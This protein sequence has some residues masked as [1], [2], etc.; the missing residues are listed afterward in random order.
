MRQEGSKRIGEEAFFKVTGGSQAEISQSAG[1][2]VIGRLI[3]VQVRDACR[4][5]PTKLDRGT[6]SILHS[7]DDFYGVRRNRFGNRRGSGG[8]QTHTAQEFL[9]ISG[10]PD[11]VLQEVRAKVDALVQPIEQRGHLLGRLGV[12]LVRENAAAAL[13]RQLVAEKVKQV[14]RG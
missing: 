5:P 2:S 6:K 8:D 9:D 4:V 10:L 1:L 11:D 3:A 14:F 7:V 12:R 13:S